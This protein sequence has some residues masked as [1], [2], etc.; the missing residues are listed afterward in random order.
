MLK[1]GGATAPLLEQ[2][3][4]YMLEREQELVCMLEQ[5]QVCK[6]VLVRVLELVCMWELGRGQG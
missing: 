2:A 1:K 6:Q 5:G 3:L 4:V